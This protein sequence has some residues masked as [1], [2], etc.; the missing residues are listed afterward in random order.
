MSD[1]RHDLLRKLIRDVPDFPK[2]GIL[3]KDITPL[4]AHPRGF[5]TCLDLLGEQ[6]AKSGAESIVGMESRG[7]IF[8]AALAA[9]LRLPF[10]PARKPGKLPADKVSVEYALEYGTDTLEMHRD[11]LKPGEKTLIVDDLIATGGTAKATAELVAALGAEVAGFAFVI[12]LG[13]L[14]GRAELAPHPV[15]SLLVY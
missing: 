1:E 14:N 8:G 15:H 2:P 3:F 5:T 6:A 13:F 9:R 11:A 7:F 4:L 12:E 10:V